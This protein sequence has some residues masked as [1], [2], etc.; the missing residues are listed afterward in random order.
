MQAKDGMK[1]PGRGALTGEVVGGA[2]DIGPP[3]A[4]RGCGG[5]KAGAAGDAEAGEGEVVESVAPCGEGGSLLIRQRPLL[6]ASRRPHGVGEAPEQR[7]A[8]AAPSRPSA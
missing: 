3:P 7:S 8:R 6:T 4:G 2:E 1:N 5:M